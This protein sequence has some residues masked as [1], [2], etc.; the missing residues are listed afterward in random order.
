MV[1]ITITK[2]GDGMT[3]DF[4]NYDWDHYVVLGMLEQAKHMVNKTIDRL[5]EKGGKTP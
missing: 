3:L 2:D 5:R 1:K 4:N